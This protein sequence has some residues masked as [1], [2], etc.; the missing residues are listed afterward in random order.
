MR[1]II[2]CFIFTILSCKG[3][4]PLTKTRTPFSGNNLKINGYYYSIGKEFPDKFHEDYVVAFF[5]NSNG[6]YQ[7]IL[8]GS[9]D[10]K[11][12]NE[13]I[14]KDLDQ[15]LRKLIENDRNY[16]DSRPNWGV[17]LVNNEMILIENWEFATGGGAYP[18]RTLEGKIVDDTTIHFHKLIGAYPNNKG[19][20][21]KIKAI[22]ETYYFRK[23]SP[24]P[25]ST[26]LCIT[27]NKKKN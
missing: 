4:E 13:A 11:L 27:S 17:F 12:N 1:I 19:G 21:K 3:Y 14:L 20:E 2:T 5:L 22:D 24:K 8:T 9:I 16:P 7:K 26:N 18:T 10:L 25:D 6:T 23:F 15:S